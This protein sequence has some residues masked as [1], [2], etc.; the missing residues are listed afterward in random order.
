[1]S[2]LERARRW[3]QGHVT[4]ETVPA[5][6]RR[7]P[8][9]H[10]IIL[11]G[12]LSTL[13][14][15]QE[16][17]AALLFYLLTKES[18]STAR[19]VYY[20]PGQ[21]WEGWR[22]GLKIIEGRGVNPQIRRAYGWL[23]SH[24]APGDRIFLFGYS[25]GAFAVRSIAGVID[26][27]G[28]LRREHATER[29]V[30][31][32]FRHYHRSPNSIAAQDFARHFCYPETVIQMVGV[33]DTVKALGL[34]FPWF[35][36]PPIATHVFHDHILGDSTLRGFH[37]LA[38]NETRAIF[39]PILWDTTHGDPSR[40]EQVWFTGAHGDI[41]G[42]IGKWVQ[43]RPLANIPLVWMLEK[44]EIMGLALPDGWRDYYPTDPN[45][46]MVGTLRGF[47]LWFLRR[48]TRIVGRDASESVHPS[49]ALRRPRFWWLR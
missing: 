1:M 27:I 13:A 37:A 21:Q 7:G 39:A 5:A 6:P 19:N 20:E 48:S 32:A 25:R 35:F 8:Q 29:G 31:T 2:V 41:G 16:G 46:P 15:G 11:D 4:V 42:N 26:R 36:A 34:K 14:Q 28:L 18:R 24:Y 3:W 44:A 12:T 22:N 33:W 43:C 30:R 45:A 23:A 40:V 47:G 10:V 38:L 9:D 17:N 49:V